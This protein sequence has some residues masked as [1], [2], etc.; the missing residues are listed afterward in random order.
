MENA[1]ALTKRAPS[2]G[3]PKGVEENYK[4]TT[5]LASF[6]VDQSSTWKSAYFG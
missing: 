1:P 2:H 5:A 6:V 3:T 4:V